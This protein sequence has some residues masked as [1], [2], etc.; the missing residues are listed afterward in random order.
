MQ[1]L[2]TLGIAGWVSAR[3]GWS[4]SSGL[5]R[6]AREAALTVRL[7]CAT[8]V[9]HYGSGK[10]FRSETLLALVTYCYA[11]GCFDSKEIESMAGRDAGLAE[12]CGSECPDAATI[13]R[14]RR[15]QREALLEALTQVLARSST[16][17][18]QPDFRR[19]ACDR[20]AQAIFADFIARDC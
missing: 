4:E 5:V 12:I 6:L 10:A 1:S 9:F 20:V 13:A 2:E 7:D 15:V 18:M 19:E 11:R 17:R 3:N 16:A 8:E 14:F